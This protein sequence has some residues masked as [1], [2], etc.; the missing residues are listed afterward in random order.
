MIIPSL[1]FLADILPIKA[2]IPGTL[3]AARLILRLMLAIVS[4]WLKKLSWM[5]YAWL[6]MLSVIS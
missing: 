3:L 4:P 5:A 2:L 1:L 6:M